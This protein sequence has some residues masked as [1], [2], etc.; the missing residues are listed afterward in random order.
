MHLYA[1]SSYLNLTLFF[2]AFLSFESS[3]ISEFQTI[4]IPLSLPPHPSTSKS[5]PLSAEDTISKP[6][7]IAG[8][9]SFMRMKILLRGGKVGKQMLFLLI[10]ECLFSLQPAIFAGPVQR[11]DMS[12]W[13]PIL[14]R[15]HS[16]D[17]LSKPDTHDF[18]SCLWKHQRN[19]WPTFKNIYLNVANEQP[20]QKTS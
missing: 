12:A 19:H 14:A 17:L 3:C 10:S 16:V 11:S 13:V 4:S 6:T 1:F 2:Y 15:R 8:S 9:R 5:N 18:I 20:A 7:L